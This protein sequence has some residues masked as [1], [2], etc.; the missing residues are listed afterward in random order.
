MQEIVSFDIMIYLGIIIILSLFSEYLYT[1]ISREVEILRRRMEKDIEKL[2]RSKHLSYRF[3]SYSSF[4][5]ICFY[6]LLMVLITYFV[7]QILMII[8]GNN[9]GFSI[10]IV[11]IIFGGY[12]GLKIVSELNQYERRIYWKTHTPSE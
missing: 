11:L 5:W 12:R 9:P 2:S 8:F 7:G 1:G 4:L 3:H 10:I 6:L